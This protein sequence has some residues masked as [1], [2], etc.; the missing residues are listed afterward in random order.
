MLSLAF[1]TVVI[2]NACKKNTLH[3]SER[4]ST[5]NKSFLRIAYLVP[6]VTNQGVQVKINDQ[7]VSS[8][9]T[10]SFGLP[11]GGTNIGGANSTDYLSVDPGQVKV[12]LSLPKAGTS[13]DS[14]A[15][16]NTTVTVE[17]GN[18]NTLYIT[19]SF[20]AISSFIVPDSAARPDSGFIQLRFVHAMPD[21]PAVDVYKNS[22][23]LFSNVPYKG[24]STYTTT[25]VGSDTFKIRTAGAAPNAAT[26]VTRV[27]ATSNQKVYVFLSRGYR[28]LSGTRGPQLSNLLVN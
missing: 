28:T 16:F 13:T 26:I 2:I 17:A 3:T 25:S 10:Y 27:F 21:I 23:L 19:D 12:G 6:S 5:E 8:L 15:L 24:S 11:G 14:I 20:P 18:R 1:F 4:E 9:L 22:V 7:R